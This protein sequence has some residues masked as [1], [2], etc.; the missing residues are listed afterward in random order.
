MDLYSCDTCGVVLDRSKMT[1]PK[2][3]HA[4][5]PDDETTWGVIDTDKAVWVTDR[6]VAKA[7]CPVCGAA[8]PKYGDS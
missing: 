4:E 7:D 8:I 6:Y 1:F 3:I 5:D 2:D